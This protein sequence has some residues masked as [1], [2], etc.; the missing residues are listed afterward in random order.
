MATEAMKILKTLQYPPCN[1]DAKAI[2]LGKI[3]KE[4]D[5]HGKSLTF[6]AVWLVVESWVLKYSK[7][8]KI[9]NGCQENQS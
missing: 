1:V 7:Y 8:S 3:E 4:E 5:F 6:G 2:G 9:F